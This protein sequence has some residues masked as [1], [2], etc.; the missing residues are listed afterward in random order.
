MR[1]ILLICALLASG[2]E[3]TTTNIRPTNSPL[4]AVAAAAAAAL[5]CAGPVETRPFSPELPQVVIASGC[6]RSELLVRPI[7]CA[8]QPQC[9]WMSKRQVEELKERSEFGLRSANQALETLNIAQALGARN[10][11][12]A[13]EA[14]SA[15][16]KQEEESRRKAA[17]QAASILRARQAAE[18]AAA[19]VGR[20]QS[21]APTSKPPM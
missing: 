11:R 12:K 18:A 14:A 7:A 4:N 5:Q 8:G 10:V 17:E 3:E 1:Q 15:E 19:A 13:M 2:C 21:A 9:A 16:M 6:N 20:S